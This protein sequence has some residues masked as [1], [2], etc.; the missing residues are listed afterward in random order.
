M[1][2]RDFAPDRVPAVGSV[3]IRVSTNG[4][5]KPRWRRD[6]TELYYVAPDKRL[7]AVPIRS[8]PAFG[9]GLPVTLFEVRLPTTT[10]PYDVAV[11]GRFLVNTLDHPSPDVPGGLTVVL[12]WAAR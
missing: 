4:G 6:G 7:M 2:V 1:Y 3:R 11:D 10:F 5:D 12:N 8:T 9:V